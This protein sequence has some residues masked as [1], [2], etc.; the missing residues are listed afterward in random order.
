M[1]NLQKLQHKIFKFTILI[2]GIDGLIDLLTSLILLISSGNVILKSIPFLTRK[3]LIED[4][5]DLIANY[6]INIAQNF[7]PDTQKFIIL[8]LAIH[9]LIKMGIALALNTNNYRAYKISGT[10]LAL[11]IIY[12]FYRFT[13]THSLTL[14]F[15]SFF[16]IF[17][18]ILIYFESK[19]F[20][21]K[22]LN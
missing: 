14:L 22:R 18:L 17:I 4:P 7:L 9:G 6:L 12:Q 5:Q 1:L 16:D 11:F 13:H 10:V 2:K 8:Y 15:F 3:E 19:K 20:L 21:Q